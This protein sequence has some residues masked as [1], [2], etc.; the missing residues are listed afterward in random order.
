MQEYNQVDLKK[1]GIL[2]GTNILRFTHSTSSMA[3][4]ELHI[5]YLNN[6]LLQ[7]NRMNIIYLYLSDSI[8]ED[9]TEVLIGNGKLIKI[10]LQVRE[11]PVKEGVKTNGLKRLVER[12][13]SSNHYYIFKEMLPPYMTIFPF[14]GCKACSPNPPIL[15]K[16]WG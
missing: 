6:T 13:F 8:A 3:G 2:D 9:R 12:I 11:I 4:S 14:S 1:G 16:L 5:D 7:R 10:P 15:I